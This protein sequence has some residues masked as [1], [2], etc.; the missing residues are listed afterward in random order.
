MT[1]K[2]L[3]YYI[4]HPD[5]L[6][7][8]EAERLEGIG[9][10]EVAETLGEY[11]PKLAEVAEVSVEQPTEKAESEVE[12]KADTVEPDGVE[13]RDGKHV[14][15][16]WRLADAE[17][18]AR[19]L[20]AKLAEYE[21]AAKTPDVP[22][23]TEITEEDLQQFEGVFP[24]IGKA[25]KASHTEVRELRGL[26]KTLL[27]ERETEQQARL[28]AIRQEAGEARDANPKLSWLYQ[29]DKAG[30]ER[31]AD[32]DIMLRSAPEW[33]GKPFSERFEKV[34]SGYEALHGEIPVPNKTLKQV[35]I[36]KPTPR[37]NV[38]VSMSTIQG[39]AAPP[40]DEASAM[41]LKTGE[42]LVNM[43]MSMSSE[44][45]ERALRRL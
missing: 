43:F 5:E 21:A 16:Y 24:A 32:I 13:S 6:T 41:S 23:L 27:S 10:T 37:P 34:V 14:I 3:E 35:E 38:P 15:P 33:A 4:D 12:V 18:K 26:V 9:G 31:A 28:D 19:A 17:A 7:D 8:A 36:P 1:E 11:P 22:D 25:V 39:G 2:T 44:Q 45:I 40:V 20:A 42:E 29:H 30:Y